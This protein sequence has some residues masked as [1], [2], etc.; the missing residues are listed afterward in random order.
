MTTPVPVGGYSNLASGYAREN[1]ANTVAWVEKKKQ[2][3]LKSLETAEVDAKQKAVEALGC[4]KSKWNQWGVSRVLFLDQAIDQ[5]LLQLPSALASLIYRTLYAAIAGLGFYRTGAPDYPRERF[6][7]SWN[8]FKSAAGYLG[9]GIAGVISPALSV[10]LENKISGPKP[11][12][13]AVGA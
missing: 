4:L 3:V 7:A 5:G 8:N 11:V 10:W 12:T 1:Y 9:Y 6:I 2:W 13:P